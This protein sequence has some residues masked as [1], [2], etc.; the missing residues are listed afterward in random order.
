VEEIEAIF[1]YDRAQRASDIWW[2]SGETNGKQIERSVV[3]EWA[4][5]LKRKT[6]D[7]Q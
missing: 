5:G 6:D 4:I 2:V 3:C 7:L 1:D